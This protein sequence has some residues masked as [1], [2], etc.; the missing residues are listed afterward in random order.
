MSGSAGCCSWS[1]RE[2]APD[3]PRGAV[4]AGL[5]LGGLADRPRFAT[6]ELH[7]RALEQLGERGAVRV[8]D[9][10]TALVNHGPSTSACARGRGRARRYGRDLALVI[11]D[12]DPSSRSTTRYGHQAGDAV[13]RR[14]ARRLHS[15]PGKS[16]MRG[17]GRRG[18]ARRVLPARRPTRRRRGRPDAPARRG[19]PLPTPRHLFSAGTATWSR[20]RRR[21]S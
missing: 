12:I 16:E 5:T 10:L 13:L 21:P 8:L 11:F 14:G 2:P 18:R 3:A 9:P 17:P 20:R 19:P 1:F 6:A 15:R 4:R 7:A